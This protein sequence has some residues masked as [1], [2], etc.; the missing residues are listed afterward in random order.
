MSGERTGSQG[1]RTDEIDYVTIASTGDAADF[2]NLT[3]K[4]SIGRG[5]CSNAH[6]GLQ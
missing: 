5:A 6:G 3:I 2:G 4:E 1:T